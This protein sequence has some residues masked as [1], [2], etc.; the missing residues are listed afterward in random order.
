MRWLVTIATFCTG[1]TQDSSC[2]SD[3]CRLHVCA[4]VIYPQMGITLPQSRDAV[5]D[6]VGC[7]CNND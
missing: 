4:R 6:A 1:H 7:R 2:T 5:G 3:W